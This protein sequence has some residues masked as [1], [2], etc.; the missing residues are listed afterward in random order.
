MLTFAVAPLILI[1]LY[2]YQRQMSLKVIDRNLD[3]LQRLKMLCRSSVAIPRIQRDDGIVS[4]ISESVDLGLSCSAGLTQSAIW[5]RL[6]KI[7]SLK[8]HKLICIW[9]FRLLA[10]MGISLVV[11]W[12]LLD[13]TYYAVFGISTSDRYL[14][15]FSGL[16]ALIGTVMFFKLVPRVGLFGGYE[17]DGLSTWLRDRIFVESGLSVTSSTEKILNFEASE[18]RSGVGLASEKIEALDDVWRA[19]ID[20]IEK[21]VER[22]SEVMPFLELVFFGLFILCFLL[23]PS[24]KFAG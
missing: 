15:F 23:E 3:L 10:V 8:A 11:R 22:A 17:V 14:I 16:A 12:Y 20:A 1:Y 5:L 4:V 19:R 2:W 9:I 21:Q 7:Q 18:M 6:F 24:L 13:S